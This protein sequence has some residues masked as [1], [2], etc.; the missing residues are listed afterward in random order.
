MNIRYGL[1]RQYLD[2]GVSAWIRA[3][4]AGRL[5]SSKTTKREDGKIQCTA[6]FELVSCYLALDDYMRL[7]RLKK[8]RQGLGE[9]SIPS[10]TRSSSRLTQDPLAGQMLVR[11]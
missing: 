10:S 4:M 7:A 3:D 2:S 11:F 1:S 5:R 9:M 8:R 6:F